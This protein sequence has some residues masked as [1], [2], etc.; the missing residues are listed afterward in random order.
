MT[1][2]EAIER[3]RPYSLTEDNIHSCAERKWTPQQPD[4]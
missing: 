1:G 2:Q 3:A 4:F